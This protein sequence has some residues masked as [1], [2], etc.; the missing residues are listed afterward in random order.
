MKKKK[1]LTLELPKNPTIGNLADPVSKYLFKVADMLANIIADKTTNKK[2]VKLLQKN[3]IHLL[4]CV[5][6]LRV[7]TALEKVRTTHG[8]SKKLFR[9][10]K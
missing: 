8:N 7:L 2:D 1:L 5:D 3:I 10:T 9:K 6:F 4:A